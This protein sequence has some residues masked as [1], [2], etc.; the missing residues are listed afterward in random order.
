MSLW[1]RNQP[2]NGHTYSEENTNGEGLAFLL[3]ANPLSFHF[4][5]ECG[6][7]PKDLVN[8]MIALQVKRFGCSINLDTRILI[9]NVKLLLKKHDVMMVKRAIKYSSIVA[10]H[11]YS[12]KFVESV[13]PQIEEKMI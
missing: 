12:F 4:K 8:Y 7:K 2:P 3:E 13:I 10:D 5:P 6:D 9:R 11:P 1:K